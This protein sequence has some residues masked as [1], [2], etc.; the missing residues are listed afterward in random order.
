M[1][2]AAELGRNPVSEHQ[3]QPEYEDEQTDAGRDYRT[4]LATPNS[5]TRTW[6]QVN[7]NFPC[8]ADHEQDWQPNRVDPYSCYI[9]VTIRRRPDSHIT[10]VLFCFSLLFTWRCRFFRVY[11]VPLPFSLSMEST[12]YV[13]PFRMMFFY[14]ETPGWIFSHQFIM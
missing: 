12:S 11:F 2:T 13:F 3:I 7:I 9:C 10:C 1:D 4:R 14:L 5:Q 8:S 6:T